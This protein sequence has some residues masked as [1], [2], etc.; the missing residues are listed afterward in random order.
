MA[1]PT[2]ADRARHILDAIAKIEAFTADKTFEDYLADDMRRHAIERCLEIAS[3]ASRHIPREM[4]ARHAEI[5]WRGVAD[6]GNV[7]RHDYPNVK[8]RRVWEI[9]IHDLGPLKAAVARIARDL[10]AKKTESP[11]KGVR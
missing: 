4:K 6:F 10:E 9:V 5:A 11:V 7:L 8:D 3:E 2:L 1:R